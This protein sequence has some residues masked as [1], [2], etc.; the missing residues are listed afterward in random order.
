[1]QDL[2]VSILLNVSG[3]RLEVISQITEK[4]LAVEVL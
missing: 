4:G 2:F 3:S 1:M